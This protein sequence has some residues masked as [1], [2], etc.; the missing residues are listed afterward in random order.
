M[1]K[2][3]V[4]V[5]DRSG[6]MSG[7]KITQA[8]EALRFILENLNAD[9]RF[10]VVSFS[11]YVEAYQTSLEPV[12]SDAVARAVSWTSRLEAS[13][14]TDLDAA[15]SIAFPLF[16]ANDRPRF[17]VFLTDGEATSG[18]TDPL[19][20]AQNAL[21]SNRVDA[22]LFVFGVGYD[23]NTVLLDQL[24]SENRGTTNYVLPGEDLEVTLSA[25]Y[26]KIS[27]PSCKHGSRD[28]LDLMYDA[29]PRELPDL[30]RGNATSRPR[31]L[32]RRWR[33]THHHLGVKSAASPQ[34]SRRCRS[35]QRS[36]SKPRSFRACGPG[37]RSPIS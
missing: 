20:I 28:P 36:A 8:K 24:A 32:P 35:S 15:L 6:S 25:F 23:V 4:F 17:L 34:P 29:F 33:S 5:L 9:D 18:E 22:R 2:D 26:R 10:A 37:G 7:E 31:S 12:S 14:G 1:P 19:I 11:D 30:F 13:G 16:E 27:L 21:E 3:L